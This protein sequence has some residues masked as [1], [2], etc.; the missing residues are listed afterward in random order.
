MAD[1][2]SSL[3]GWVV[4]PASQSL[5]FAKGRNRRQVHEVDLKRCVDYLHVNPLKH[6][7]VRQVRFERSL[8]AVT[9]P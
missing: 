5:C 6:G 8:A 3:E 2:R 1:G 9:S 7:Q 4:L